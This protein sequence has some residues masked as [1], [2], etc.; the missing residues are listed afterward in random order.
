MSGRVW[1]A[2]VLML[3]LSAM[4]VAQAGP[5]APV[6]IEVDFL[7]GYIEGSG[8]LF[9]RNGSWHDAKAAQAHI[10]DKYQYLVV[11]DQIDTTEHFIERAATRSSLSGETYKVRCH[12]GETMTT[13]LWLQEELARFRAFNKKPASSLADPGP[14]RANLGYAVIADVLEVGIAL[15]PTI[16]HPS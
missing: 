3:G 6:Q 14:T 15:F 10:R 2:L 12:G 13:G 8:C 16:N 1:A 11:R 5:P 7:L 9:Y 4:P